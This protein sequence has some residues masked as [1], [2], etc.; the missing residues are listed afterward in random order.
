MHRLI[1]YVIIIYM[2]VMVTNVPY[3]YCKEAS[4]VKAVF[5]YESKGKRDPFVPLIGQEKEKGTALE[6]ITSIEDLTLEGIAIGSGGKN[7]AIL[8]GQLVK[9]D[10]KFGTLYIKKISRKKVQ[11]SIDAKDYVLDLQE[12]VEGNLKGEKK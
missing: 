9:D 4:A 7:I 10:D 8:N 2:N 1:L 11:I 5:S 3:A 6:N 12:S